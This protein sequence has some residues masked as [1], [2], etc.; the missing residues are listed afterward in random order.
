MENDVRDHHVLEEDSKDH[1]ELV[2]HFLEI[3]NF[4][5]DAGYDPPEALGDG[6][7]NEVLVLFEKLLKV[8]HYLLNKGIQTF[9]KNLC[10]DSVKLDDFFPLAFVG[11]VLSI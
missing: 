10:G 6:V 1:V 3:L 7:V 11:I 8:Q 2:K 9:L 4:V 5:G